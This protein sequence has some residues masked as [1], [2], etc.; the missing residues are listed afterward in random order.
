MKVE[1]DVDGLE[2]MAAR[3]CEFVLLGSRKV[4]KKRI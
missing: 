3:M 2:L 4:S 1:R